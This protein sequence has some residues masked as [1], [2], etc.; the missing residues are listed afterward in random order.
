[1]LLSS[2]D[3]FNFFG[4]EEIC[5]ANHN[6]AVI[7]AIESLNLSEYPN[8]LKIDFKCIWKFIL[9]LPF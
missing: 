2:R 4:M 7:F 6:M 3:F 1:M 9:R 8:L 5:Y